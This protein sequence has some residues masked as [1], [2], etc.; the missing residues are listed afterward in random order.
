MSATKKKCPV[1]LKMRVVHDGN[2]A[3]GMY[4]TRASCD[5]T[6]EYS[7]RSLLYLSCATDPFSLRVL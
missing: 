5:L 1:N 3:L 2:C 7:L 4:F 6:R